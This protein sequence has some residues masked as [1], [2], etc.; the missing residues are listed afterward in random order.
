[1]DNLK[2]VLQMEFNK[3]PE[4]VESIMDKIQEEMYYNG[5]SEVEVL[6]EVFGEDVDIL[7]K[8]LGDT[9]SA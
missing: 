9:S 3:T 4:E 8:V 6:T 1:M 2:E 7:L 5:K